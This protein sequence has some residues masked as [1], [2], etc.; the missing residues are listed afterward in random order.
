M[1]LQV[2]SCRR[3]V[4]WLL[5]SGSLL[6]L[7]LTYVTLSQPGPSPA[8]ASSGGFRLYNE[9]DVAVK[10]RSNARQAEYIDRRGVHVV[11]GKYV[12][13]SLGS[14]DPKFSPAE[15]N[16]ASHARVDPAAGAGG[17]PARA[18]SA[19]E[20]R[21]AKRLWHINK[22]NV[23]VS[24]RIP[25]NRSLPDVRKPACAAK[26]YPAATRLPSASVVIVFHNE[27]WS[28]LLRTV[29]SVIDRSPADA[30]REIILVDDA[31]NRTFLG[32]PLEA[33]VRALPVRAQLLRTPE[34]SGLIKARLLGAERATGRVLVFL[35]AHCEC[36]DGWLEPLLARI[37]ERRTALVCPVIDIISDDTFAYV[38]SFSL[39]WG[40][41]NWELHF[42]WFTMSR[43]VLE[44]YQEDVTRPY[45]SPAM[46]GGLFAVER[47]Y[48]YELVNK[49]ARQNKTCICVAP[50]Q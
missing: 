41:F 39:H 20:D 38:K 8:S 13:E 30:L 25:L 35:D 16:A 47:D 1:R 40:A 42:R 28:T 29:Q 49:A 3:R 36:T 37:A 45:R 48:F 33:A 24:D 21:R 19:G 43:A 4:F 9:K 22:F 6:F 31:S 11:V 26:Q 5:A 46:A 15:L 14:G 44:E 50:F 34:R 23:V 2:P 7:A 10:L 17:E 27:A 12:G 18:A 32:A